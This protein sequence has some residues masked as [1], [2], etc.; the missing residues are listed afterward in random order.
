MTFTLNHRPIGPD[1]P[2]YIIAELSANHNGSLERDLDTMNAAQRCGSDAIKLQ[3]YTADTMTL[4]HAEA[5]NI[6]RVEQDD[7]ES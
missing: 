1:Q 6:H 3:T 2:P 7:D 4:K 5:H